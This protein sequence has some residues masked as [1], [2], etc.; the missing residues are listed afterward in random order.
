M[1]L[2]ASLAGLTGCTLYVSMHR[3][4]PLYNLGGR[5]LW[6]IGIPPL[7]SLV[8]TR[9]YMQSI[10]IDFGANAASMILSNAGET[11]IVGR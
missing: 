4:F 11:V 5:A 1:P 6:R 10:V 2:D 7:A 3:T 9:L 8:G